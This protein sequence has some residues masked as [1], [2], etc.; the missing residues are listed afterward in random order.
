MKC[1]GSSLGSGW[2]RGCVLAGLISCTW[3]AAFASASASDETTNKVVR[4]VA[5][6]HEEVKTIPWSIHLIKVD[7]SQT[8]LSFQTV[9][10]RGNEFAL[11]PLP[12]QIRNFPLSAGKV[13]AAVNGDFYR[14]DPPYAGDPRGILISRGELM[15]GPDT[16]AA[17]FVDINGAPQVSII[18]PDFKA[19]FP[20]GKSLP[21][22]LNEE[23]TRGTVVLFT[24]AVGNSTKTE[25]GH[26]LIL[27]GVPGEKWLPLSAS[28]ITKARVLK[29]V[30]GGNSPLTPETMV[31][32]LS[33]AA[34][35]KIKMPAVGEVIELNTATTP[36][37][38]GVPTAMGG[39]P[40]LVRQGKALPVGQ[41]QGRHPRTAVGWSKDFYFLVEVDG[42]QKDSA[43][44]TYQELAE[45]MQ[46][47]GC[48]EAVNLD[49]GGSSTMWVRGNVM[50]SP[51][52]GQPR[53][54]A[55][56]LLLIYSD[57]R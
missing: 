17:F 54:M 26:E 9:A 23:R 3:L 15:S 19:S 5:Y 13:M 22:T 41:S 57:R 33:P 36:S 34:A 50:N 42:R 45:Y 56:S 49:G 38:Q 53:P 10:G 24:R 48:D 46:K 55:D 2:R 29:V 8:N 40:A 16:W 52:E 43:G 20:D 14:S 44:M 4:A 25:G 31:L 47:L 11:T 51:S 6:S 28:A 37:L 1:L 18:T 39:G 27:E 12:E 7:R 21:F 30:D 35:A 32:S